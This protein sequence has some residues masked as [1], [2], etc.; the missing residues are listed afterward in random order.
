VTRG[1]GLTVHRSDCPNVQNITD[2]E[3]LIPVTWD[4]RTRDETFPVPVIVRAHDRV[5]L[6]KDISSLLAD[7]R[8]NIL[9][10]HTRTHDNREVSIDITVEV[11]DVGQLS[12]VLH[13]LDGVQGVYEVRRDT[14]G[15]RSPA[16]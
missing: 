5:G 10:T 8:I 15:A 9:Y 11:S 2:R 7:E 12:K 13:K 16:A 6:L 1:R 14:S 4:E 3:R